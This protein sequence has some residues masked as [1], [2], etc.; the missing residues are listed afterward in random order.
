MRPQT[1]NQAAVVGL[2]GGRRTRLIVAP[3]VRTYCRD[4][5]Y[6]HP[7]LQVFDE[8]GGGKRFLLVCSACAERRGLPTAV[9]EEVTEK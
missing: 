3:L 5:D 1:A 2:A 7:C 9:Q 8:T 6:L 4:C